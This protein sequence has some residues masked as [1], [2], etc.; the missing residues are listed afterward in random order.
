MHVHATEFSRWRRRLLLF[1]SGRG[2]RCFRTDATTG[3]AKLLL[4]SN[5]TGFAVTV[6]GARHILHG[7][8]HGHARAVVVLDG[9]VDVAGV[10][11]GC[12]RACAGS[13]PCGRRRKE[14]GPGGFTDTVLIGA[15]VVRTFVK[16]RRGTERGK[17]RIAAMDR[18]PIPE[19]TTK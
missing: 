16:R 17:G 2:P 7:H 5:T 9:L 15:A 6:T 18:N 11:A 8:G 12:T 1:V 3:S 19:S 10:P 14:Q 4:G 13:A